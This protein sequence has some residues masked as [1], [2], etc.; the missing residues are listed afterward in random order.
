MAGDTPQAD[1][2]SYS[3]YPNTILVFDDGL[4]IDLTRELTPDDHA[5]LKKHFEKPFAVI[6]ASDP[7]GVPAGESDNAA[8]RR[9]L[10]R[11]LS[12][13]GTALETVRGEAVD[14]D[15]GEDGFGC[16]LPLD[17]AARIACEFSQTAFFW[18]DGTSFWLYDSCK[19]RSVSRL[20]AP[21]LPA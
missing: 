12:R 20:P 6:T 21:T 14:S 19:G 17:E 13:I 3:E 4:R 8:N 16:E 11:V 9:R 7:F 18:Y 10:E 5:A 1:D 2:P 15:H